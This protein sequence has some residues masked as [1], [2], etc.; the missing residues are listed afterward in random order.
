MR[1]RSNPIDPKMLMGGA[2]LGGVLLYFVFSKKSTTS[3]IKPAAASTSTSTATGATAQL[4]KAIASNAQS[5]T[6]AVTSLISSW[7]S[8]TPSTPAAS[9]SQVQ[10]VSEETT[11]DNTDTSSVDTSNVDTTTPDISDN[12]G[13]T[14]FAGA[15]GWARNEYGNIRGY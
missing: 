5:V 10:V 4:Q 8:S 14:E 6:P 13:D 7:F 2:L 12:S 9:A 1:S 11:A 3:V 15:F